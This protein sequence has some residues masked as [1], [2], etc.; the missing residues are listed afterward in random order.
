MTGLWNYAAPG[1]YHVWTRYRGMGGPVGQ[2][3]SKRTNAATFA[4]TLRAAENTPGKTYR[5][6]GPCHC[7]VQYFAD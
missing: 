5:I 2:A 3:Y 6:V 4:S 7:S 1:H